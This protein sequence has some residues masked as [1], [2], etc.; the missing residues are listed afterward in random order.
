[1]IVLGKD[2]TISG[3]GIDN[4]VVRNVSVNS[5][6][7]EIDTQPFGQRVSYKYAT[8]HETTL[9]VDLVEDPDLWTTLRSGEVV[10]VTGSAANGD[11]I[12]TGIARNEPLD[13]VVTVRVTLKQARTP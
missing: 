3:G 10:S 4:A 6:A 5:S 1:M 12:V 7:K 2:C 8:G 9:E 13:D 11:F